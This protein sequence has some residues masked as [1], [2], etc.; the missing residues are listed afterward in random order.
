MIQTG[1]IAA[2]AFVFGD[3]AQQLWPLGAVRAVGLCGGGA[4]YFSPLL[5]LAGTYQSKNAQ[6]I[7]TILEVAALLFVSFIGLALASPA[8]SASVTPAA[9]GGALGLAIVFILF[10]YGGWNE[11]AYLSKD[12]QDVRRNMVRILVAG[13][14]AVTLL[15]LL[16]NLA[17]LNVL[18]LEGMRKS[19]AI[20]ADVN[21]ISLGSAGAVLLSLF[22]CCAALSTI[23]ASIFTT[24]G[25]PRS[26]RTLA[27]RSLSF[28]SGTGNNKSNAITLQSAIAL[29]L[30]GF[31]ATTKEGFEAMVNYTAP[32]FFVFL[33]LVRVP[34]FVL[35]LREADHDQLIR[36]QLYPVTRRCSA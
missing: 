10:T 3:Y 35:R 28:W 19:P 6:I 2:V 5:N 30:I 25:V 24:P 22:V 20:A 1:A 27:V 13:T 11:A 9:S 17:Y 34:A 18:G 14:L 33:F 26:A 4:G 31:G 32:V 36:I 8:P 16:I 12:V 7:F 15:Y 23:N 29:A 21:H